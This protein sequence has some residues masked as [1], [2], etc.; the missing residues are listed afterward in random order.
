MH[1]GMFF[2]CSS[3]MIFFYSISQQLWWC[4][5]LCLSC[6][7]LLVSIVGFLIPRGSTISL[8]LGVL[9]FLFLFFLFTIFPL[10]SIFSS[11]AHALHGLLC[12][13]CVE[14]TH[15]HVS[16]RGFYL[17]QIHVCHDLSSTYS[18]YPSHEGC[19]TPDSSC[20]HT[21]STELGIFYL[22][23]LQT[24]FSIQ[25]APWYLLKHSSNSA[26]LF[27][28]PTDCF[29]FVPELAWKHAS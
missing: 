8:G 19:P 16:F 28:N 23:S 21:H 10:G 25:I 12:F 3:T 29:D 9:L 18:M 17:P 26:T 27:S 2:C 4:F 6:H 15:F 11:G 13:L 5:L 20:H 14:I 1:A 7:L 22:L 24:W